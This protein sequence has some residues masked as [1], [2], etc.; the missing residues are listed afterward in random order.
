MHKK[1]ITTLLMSFALTMSACQTA[2]KEKKEY[3]YDRTYFKGIYD[4]SNENN[5]NDD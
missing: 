3:T 2:K 4:L 1:I 5:N